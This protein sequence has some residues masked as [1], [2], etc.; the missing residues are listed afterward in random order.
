MG[1]KLEP[2]LIAN[3]TLIDGFSNKHRIGKKA[4]SNY[5][6]VFSK[7]NPSISETLQTHLIGDLEKFGVISDS[8]DVFVQERS[9]AIAEGLNKKLLG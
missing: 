8:Y 7:E 1:S 9:K 3:I 4:P 6:D 5:I 2:N